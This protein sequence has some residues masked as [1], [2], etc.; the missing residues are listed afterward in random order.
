MMTA[1]DNCRVR[2]VS[3]DRKLIAHDC[4]IESG[5]SGG[6]ILSADGDEEAVIEGINVSGTAPGYPLKLGFAV[7]AAS[8]MESL[9]RLRPPGTQVGPA[10]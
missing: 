9:A 8:I 10:R 3:P 5:D 1:Y 6:P 2:S 7:A 4:V